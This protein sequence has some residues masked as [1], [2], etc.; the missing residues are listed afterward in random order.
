MK[1]LFTG[2]G[3]GGHFYPIIAIAQKIRDIVYDD[4]LIEP[5]LYFM[6]VE[7]YNNRALL[8]NKITFVQ[9][10]AGKL[11]YHFS[12]ANFTDPFKSLWGIFQ[13][14]FK[15][16]SIYPDV[17]FSKGGFASVPAVLA[18][19]LLRIPLVI[20]ESDSRPGRAN[21][22]AGKF[23]TKIA[24]S[25][26][27]ALQYFPKD[28]TAVTGNPIRKDITY[29]IKEGAR[30]YLKLEEDLPILLVLGGSQ[31]AQAINNVVI[32][33]LPD[34]T[35]RYQIIH[36]T[37]KNNFADAQT[38]SQVLLEGTGRLDRYKAFPYLDDIATR[39]AAGAADLVISRAGS[40]IF[41]IATWGTPS[42]IIPI[43]ETVSHDQRTNAFTYARS[44]ACVVI[45]EN[46]L[47]Q[48][49]LLSEID[50]L[51]Q[52]PD[53]L[54]TMR[55]KTKSFARPDAAQVIARELVDICIQHE[56]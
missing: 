47:S 21:K 19:R 52:H 39:M 11:R 54:A 10:R 31:G 27:D 35:K 40:T 28:K 53:L 38:R 17:V 2:G 49:V 8:E 34:L 43:P 33:L 44:G 50:R 13:A 32:D 18:A 51:F 12:L 6:S 1:I 14:L 30:E 41:E 42:I 15:V 23:A 56:R 25:Y 36:Q 9:A 16:Y 48:S 29:P 22:W 20:H 55:E 4:K 5:D 46:N 7:P 37:G 24:L 3:T 45:E 26:P